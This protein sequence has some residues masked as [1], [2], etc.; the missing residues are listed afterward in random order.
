[1]KHTNK[2]ALSTMMALAL[3]VSVIGV[4]LAWTTVQSLPVSNGGIIPYNII[5]APE[6]KFP[7]GN[8][9]CWQLGYDFGSARANYTGGGFDAYFPAGVSVT[10]TDGTYVAWTSTFPVGA[11]IVKGSNAANI[12]EYSGGSYGDSGLASPINASD[13]S[14]GLSNLTFCWN[15]QLA[16]TKTANTS[17]DRAWA[18]GINKD[19]DKTSLT[20]SPGQTFAVNYIVTLTAT[21]VDSNWAVWGDITITNPNLT[22]AATIAS[23][24]DVISP[25]ISAPVS[26]GVTFP[27][28][29]PAGQTLT[30]TYGTTLPDGSARTNTAVAATI[31][32]VPGGSGVADV[33]FG[34]PA[35]E[36]DE[37]ITVTDDKYGTL[38]TVCA[39]DLT[40]TF[41]YTLNV[42]P[43][44]VCGDYSYVNIASFIT[45]DTGVTGSD[46]HIVLVTVPCAGGCTLTQGYWKTHS[47]YGPAP[48]D[49]TWALMLNGADTP[50]FLSTQTWYQVFWTPPAGNAYYNLAHQYMAAK[51]NA[52]NGASSTPAVNGAITYA[53]KFFNTYFPT[54]TLSKS[55]RNAVIN[56]ASILDKYNNGLIGPGHCS[57]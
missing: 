51:L 10:V 33:V 18:W 7:G 2:L 31:G 46:S 14:A 17:F 5:P 47:E 38:G 6:D 39:G 37:C 49:A 40:K 16:V 20:L 42:G 55:L 27:Y 53:E 28:I 54:S 41:T 45:N 50:F 13:G 26:C 23:V 29:L 56:K 44:D 12:Y 22:A 32:K 11:V 25:D 8:V 35:N 21:P 36:Y 43:Y 1:M 24:T 57:E 9:E 34:V 48:Y 15:L 4:A 30:C 52:L 19:G 3:L